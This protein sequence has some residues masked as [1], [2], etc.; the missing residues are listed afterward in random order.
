MK[1]SGILHIP[2]SDVVGRPM[3]GKYMVHLPGAI[4]GPAEYAAHV[5]SEIRISDNKQR[6]LPA[7]I[8]D[9]GVCSDSDHTDNSATKEVNRF[10]IPRPIHCCL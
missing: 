9:A 3:Q 4:E 7:Y 5:F 6:R 2:Y 8:T 1:T 10:S